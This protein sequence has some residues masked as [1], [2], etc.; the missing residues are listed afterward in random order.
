VPADDVVATARALAA[1]IA[2]NTAPVSVAVSKRLLWEAMNQSVAETMRAEN[3]LFGKV[4]ALDDAREGITAFFERR[5]PTWT[6][7]P[8][9]DL[10]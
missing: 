3:G 10:P 8:S 9:T 2:A 1:D 4:T 5:Q 7:R 6:G